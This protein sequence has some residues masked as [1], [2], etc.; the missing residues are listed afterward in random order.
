MWCLCLQI[1][2]HFK[3]HTFWNSESAART[4]FDAYAAR[5]IAGIRHLS[6]SGLQQLIAEADGRHQFSCAWNSRMVNSPTRNNPHTRSC[7]VNRVFLTWKWHVTLVW[8]VVSARCLFMPQHTILEVLSES[9][10]SP[11][12]TVQLHLASSHAPY[13]SILSYL[14]I[15]NLEILRIQSSKMFQSY[16]WIFLHL[17]PWNCRCLMI[18]LDPFQPS[19]SSS[20]RS[21]SRPS[22]RIVESGRID[23]V[24]L[25]DSWMPLQHH[26]INIYIY[27]NCIYI[28][29]IYTILCIYIYI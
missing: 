20:F 26:S 4:A 11:A 6:T 8:P 10:R 19:G 7:V 17:A 18:F 29:Y 9:K 28:M 22:W 13:W 1:Q 12:W 23:W 3:L 27:N 24:I 16:F 5:A 25:K 14:S 2:A 21:G 15:V